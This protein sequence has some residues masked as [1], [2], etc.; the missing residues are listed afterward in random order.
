MSLTIKA[1]VTKTLSAVAAACDLVDR[2]LQNHAERVAY[3]AQQ[4]GSH[5]GLD[6]ERLNLLTLSSLVHDIG[7]VTTREKLELADFNP[8]S[9]IVSRH[10]KRGY[11]LL[12][13]TRYLQ[14]LAQPVLEHHE[15]YREDLDLIPAIIFVADRVE[16]LLHRDEYYL[17]QTDRVVQ[18][19]RDH[20]GTIFHPEVVECFAD[21]AQKP[22]LW[23]D[24]QTGNYVKAIRDN[25][26]MMHVLS[27]E[28]LEDIAELFATIVDSKSP[29]TATHSSGLAAKAAIMAE[30]LGMEPL[31]VRQMRLAALLHDI[32]KLAVPEEIL[33]A[34][35]KLTREEFAVM[36]QHTYHTYYLIGMLGDGLESIQRW[37]AYHHERLDGSGYPFGLTGDQLDMECRLM[38]VLDV[39]QALTEDRP[40]RSPLSLEETGAILR[41]E[42]QAGHLDGDLV[43]L[44]MKHGE[45]LINPAS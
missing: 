15:H 36:Q 13:T 29:F 20:I 44:I 11:D 42:V 7:I 14:A 40:Y 26:D 8:D 10:A 22:S 38:A 9:A 24:L 34:P 39:F 5:I 6:K 2:R 25:P 18:R 23:L 43:D 17:W 30:K 4:I 31:K 32:G 41:K 19:V 21:L 37:A 35:R 3:I 16:L 27:M 45:E 33:V 28:E 12:M 1:D